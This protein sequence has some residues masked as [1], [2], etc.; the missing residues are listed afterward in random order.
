MELI[1]IRSRWAGFMVAG[2]GALIGP[3][4]AENRE[5][6][7]EMTTLTSRWQA[8]AAIVVGSLIAGLDTTIVV[9]AQTDPCRPSWVPP[10]TAAVDFGRLQARPG[11]LHDSCRLPPSRVA[12]RLALNT[13]FS[14]TL[15]V[16]EEAF[17]PVWRCLRIG[18]CEASWPGIATTRRKCA[19]A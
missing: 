10:P 9:L 16:I 18:C 6:S 12:A 5:D 11:H 19:I 8:L 4:V 15:A 1:T 13:L 7:E 2:L 14:V 17:L 3:R